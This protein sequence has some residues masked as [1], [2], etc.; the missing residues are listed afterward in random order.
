MNGLGT[1]TWR[2]TFAGFQRKCVMYRGNHYAATLFCLSL[3]FLLMMPAS[4]SGITCR[5]TGAFGQTIIYESPTSVK[6][7]SLNWNTQTTIREGTVTK[8]NIDYDSVCYNYPAGSIDYRNCRNQAKRFFGDNCSDLKEKYRVTKSPYN[9]AYK[10]DLDCFCE[11]E[12]R[13]R[14]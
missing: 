6:C 2:Q 4:A 13:F 11:A 14:P 5:R 7:Y 8:K 12:F 1:H 10:L 9:E 3:S